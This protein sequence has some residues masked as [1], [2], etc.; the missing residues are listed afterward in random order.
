MQSNRL[1]SVF[2]FTSETIVA[3]KNMDAEETGSILVPGNLRNHLAECV[4]KHVFADMA[5]QRKVPVQ[6]FVRTSPD[7]PVD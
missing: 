1:P 3:E 7:D 6:K 2:C 5:V 4:R